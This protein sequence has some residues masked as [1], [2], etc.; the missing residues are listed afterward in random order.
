MP[1]ISEAQSPV[2]EYLQR[3]QNTVAEEAALTDE[4]LSLGQE[5]A[6]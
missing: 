5:V 2:Y 4:A 3:S 1:R 6:E